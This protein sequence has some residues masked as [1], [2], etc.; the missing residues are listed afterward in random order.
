MITKITK[1]QLKKDLLKNP[2]LKTEIRKLE[3]IENQFYIQYGKVLSTINN[4]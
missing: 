3:Q 4:H 2:K 1:E